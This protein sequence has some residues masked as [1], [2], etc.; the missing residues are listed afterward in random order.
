MGASAHVRIAADHHP[1]KLWPIL[2]GATSSGRKGTAAG[3]AELVVVRAD[4]G[5]ED[6]RATNV[7]SGEVLIH[8]VRDDQT[9]VK[10][11]GSFETIPGVADK[12]LY[13]AEPEFAAVLHVASRQGSI[14]SPVIRQAWDKNRLR[15]TV[16]NNPAIATGA[17]ITILGHITPD[18]LR[19]DLT[20]TDTANGFAN[21]FMWV[22][23]RRSKQLPRG[24]QL[25]LNAL[26]PIA[27][28]LRTMIDYAAHIERVEHDGG[29][30]DL[31]TS[32]YGELS[33]PPP[34]MLGAILGR[35]LPYIHRIALV[36]ALL[37]GV[38]LITR[39]HLESALAVWDYCARS[40]AY[41]FG[42]TLGDPT[43]DLILRELQMVASGGLDQTTLYRLL[44]N[45][46]TIVPALSYLEQAGL[47]YCVQEE[48]KGRPRRVW[49]AGQSPVAD[50]GGAR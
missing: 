7:G 38:D 11:D 39:K 29:F 20:R 45:N 43:A 33:T 6:R 14:L 46:R 50:A 36:Y 40:A 1:A 16:K 49:L 31:W 34:G 32:C 15:H 26:E 10:R 18:E 22:C 41:V 35:A 8:E 25:D 28:R 19:R 27:S 48:T 37:D 12:R 23:V 4:P 44:S 21:R 47:A 3:V 17:H 42:G 30:W 24:D 5:W 9:R 2:V 13:V